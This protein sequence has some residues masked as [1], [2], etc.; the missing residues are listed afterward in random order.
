MTARAAVGW[1]CL[2][3]VDACQR[4]NHPTTADA[5]AVVADFYAW[6]VPR[7]R[8]S[9]EFDMAALRQKPALVSK[10]LA[11]AL[12]LDSAAR[13][14]STNEVAGLD[15]DPFLNAQDPCE[16][17]APIGAIEDNGRFLI[18]VLGTGGCGAHPIPDVTV[19]VTPTAGR[20]VFTN[21]I[22]SS[23]DRDNLVS[24]LADLAVA[25]R[26]TKPEK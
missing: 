8:D 22:Y 9:A 10:S 1:A 19:E 13:A 4:I 25:R 16:H 14:Q 3:A 6:Y 21:F 26:L 7:Q 17:Y 15:S 18:G 23:G 12:R 11:E 24:T 5:R 20:L 2:P